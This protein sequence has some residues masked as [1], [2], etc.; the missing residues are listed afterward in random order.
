[1]VERKVWNRNGVRPPSCTTRKR[2]AY[3]TPQ[4]PLCGRRGSDLLKMAN[5]QKSIG[6]T[7]SF[8]RL[9]ILAIATHF[10]LLFGVDL[11]APNITSVFSQIQELSS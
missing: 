5:E 3:S 2:E 9:V 6:H 10:I 4:Q 7:S 1:M 11:T 8:E